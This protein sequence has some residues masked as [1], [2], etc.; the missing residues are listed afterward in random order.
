MTQPWTRRSAEA[1]LHATLAEVGIAETRARLV[2][3]RQNA[4]FHLADN[5]KSLRIY[6]PGEDPQR[7]ERMVMLARH[8]AQ[9]DFPSI[10]ICALPGT[11]PFPV[12]GFPA[13]LWHWIEEDDPKPDTAGML[14]RVLRRLH[15]LPGCEVPD[16]PAFD[17]VGKVLGRLERLRAAATIPAGGLDTLRTALARA[18]DM[19]GELRW[20]RLGIGVIHGDAMPGNIV[21]SSGAPILIDLDSAARGAREWDLVPMGVVA[22][23]FSRSGERWRRFLAGYGIDER[24]LPGLEAACLVKELTIT[25][26]LCLSAGQSA[27]IDDEIRRRLR[28]WAEWDIAGRWRSD[29]T[30]TPAA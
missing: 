14:G 29:F 1:A 30:W 27:A 25:S 18:L 23:R 13:S 7:A 2:S 15:D 19:G 24:D 3:F 21:V 20:S 6:G 9:L 12:G 10:R 11:Q 4:V 26:Y 16:L 22:R 17:P 28:M 5:G 8:L